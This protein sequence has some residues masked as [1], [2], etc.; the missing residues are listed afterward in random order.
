MARIGIAVVVGVA[1]SMLPATSLAAP[2]EEPIRIL[3][4][5]DDDDRSGVADARETPPRAPTQAWLNDLASTNGRGKAPGFRVRRVGKRR[6]L[7]ALTPGA[8]RWGARRVVR[9][10]L[11]PLDHA[12]RGI[13][14]AKSHVSLSRVLPERLGG[15]Q[16]RDAVRWMVAMPKGER[17]SSIA[18]SSHRLDGSPLDRLDNVRLESMPCPAQYSRFACW[19]TLPIRA[20]TDPIDRYHPGAAPTSVLAEVGGTIRARLPGFVGSMSVRVGGP[21]IPELSAGRYRGRLR[22]RLVRATAGGKPPIGHTDSEALAAARREV[23]VASALWGQCG[24]HFGDAKR[25]DI[26]LV[27]PPA[28]SLVTVGCALGVPATGGGVVKLKVGS[29]LLAVRTFRGETAVA[30]ARRLDRAIT[31]GGFRVSRYVNRRVSQGAARTVDLVVRNRQKRPVAVSAMGRPSTD[32]SLDVCI[33]DVNLAD[34]LKH[35]NDFSSQTGTVEERALLRAFDDGDP[36]TIEILVVPAFAQTGRIGESFIGADGSSLANAVIVDQKAILAGARSFTL[37]HELGHIFLDVPGHPDDYG[38]DR[39]WQLMDSDA[40]DET[41]FGPRR[42][43]LP[44]CRRAIT[45]SGPASPTPLL[46][47]WPLF[48]ARPRVGGR[49]R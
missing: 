23:R 11:Q 21:R 39:S 24:I 20:S 18:L 3:V 35:F 25:A 40:A 13:D 2:N 5:L 1:G 38:V 4:D 6:M 31:A 36:S 16:D 22:I 9:A 32:A 10:L 17:A 37:A 15:P 29:K 44:E 26:Q 42:L 47:E 43:S 46:A 45:Q 19:K 14:L 28:A 30:F 34:G 8:A 33:G 12:G 27:D 41:I 48:A 49:S 7:Q